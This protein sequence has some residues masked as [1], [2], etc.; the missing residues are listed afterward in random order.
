[1]DKHSF[2]C[3]AWVTLPHNI[4]HE[5]E[6]RIFGRFAEVFAMYCDLKK[7]KIGQH[8]NLFETFFNT[9]LDGTCHT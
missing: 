4:P 7:V 3:E 9:A 2:K 8:L 1:M 5:K 6:K